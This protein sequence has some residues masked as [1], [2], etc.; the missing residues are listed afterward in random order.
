MVE[1]AELNPVKGCVRLTEAECGVQARAR[2]MKSKVEFY[3]P[4][5]MILLYLRKSATIV[6]SAAPPCQGAGRSLETTSLVNHEVPNRW[7]AYWTAL[8]F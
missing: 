5:D 4:A 6:G 2:M 7:I 8:W 3:S 1:S